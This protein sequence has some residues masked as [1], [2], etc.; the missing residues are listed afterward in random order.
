MQLFIYLE[1][2]VLASS[3][4]TKAQMQQGRMS[5]GCSQLGMSINVK[6][7]TNYA[8]TKSSERRITKPLCWCGEKLIYV[9]TYYM[10]LELYVHKN[11]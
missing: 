1:H 11:L 10:S 3:N 9:N 5:D 7:I 6:K 8:L 2:I 4:P